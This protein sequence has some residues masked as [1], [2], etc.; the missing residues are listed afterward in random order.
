MTTKPPSKSEAKSAGEQN[1]QQLLDQKLAV[2]II[3][4]QAATDVIPERQIETFA[5]RFAEM[6]LGNGGKMSVAVSRHHSGP[7]PPE[8]TIQGYAEAYPEAPKI[9]F[10]MAQKDQDAFISGRERQ[11]NSDNR[12]RLIAYGG[13]L[14]ALI[15]VLSFATALALL[16]QP[17]I[18]GG[19]LA[20]GGTATIA[21][22]VNAWK[23]G[24]TKTKEPKNKAEKS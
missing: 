13:G 3:A 5:R 8:E 14:F 6:M 17:E 7:L 10:E 19:I 22:F 1:P 20:L 16:G 2:E 9:I 23:P 21:T 15:V 12:F 11:Q 4:R 24:W 18:A